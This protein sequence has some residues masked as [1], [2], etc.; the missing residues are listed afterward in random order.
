MNLEKR[1]KRQESI[2]K[3]YDKTAKNLP[4]VN[5]GDKI[6]FQSPEGK[7]WSKGEI[8]KMGLRTYII[9]AANGRTYKRNLVH[10][11]RN[12]GQKF[13][14]TKYDDHTCTPLFTNDSI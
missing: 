10:I 14:K 7:E 9:Q 6:Y 12:L 3:Q 2:R 13:S 8:I 4:P 5:F 11:R 1:R